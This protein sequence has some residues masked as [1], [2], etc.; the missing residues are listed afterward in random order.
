MIRC[1]R[2]SEDEASLKSL[3]EANVSIDLIAEE[4]KRTTQSVKKRAY[5]LRISTKRVWV[6]LK[7]KR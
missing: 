4:M 5:A 6:G 7:A 3:I 2:T 1:A